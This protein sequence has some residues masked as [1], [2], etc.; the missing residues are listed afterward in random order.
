M[1][2]KADKASSD[3]GDMAHAWYMP[4]V[5]VLR[6]DGFA[7]QYMGDVADEFGV[8]LVTRLEDLPSVIRRQLQ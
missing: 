4:Y 3:L 1:P 8:R 7:G 2:R 5:D 6:V